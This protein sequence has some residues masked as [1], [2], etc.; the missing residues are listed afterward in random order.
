M[1]LKPTSEGRKLSVSFSGSKN[2]LCF[3]MVFELV[4]K[5]SLFQTKFELLRMD[6]KKEGADAE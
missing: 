1:N 5:S 4:Q 3:V 6:L 2:L